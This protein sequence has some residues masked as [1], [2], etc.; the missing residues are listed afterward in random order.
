[1][2][3]V[4]AFFRF[5]LN[6]LMNHLKASRP[7][8][9]E[10]T[11]VLARTSWTFPTCLSGSPCCMAWPSCTLWC[12]REGSLDPSDGI[13][14]TSST[15]L[16]STPVYS[17]YRTI[18]MTWTSKRSERLICQIS[19]IVISYYF[20]YFAVLMKLPLLQKRYIRLIKN[21]VE[22][23]DQLKIFNILY[24]LIFFSLWTVIFEI[25]VY[26]QNTR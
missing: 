2:N 25:E 12:K 20:H 16:T 9:R 26:Y 21:L 13:F 17:L 10:R 23:G 22:N 1:M 8:W 18:W 6:S 14:H 7:V 4:F 24:L 3:L 19:L 11:L 5:Q 15:L